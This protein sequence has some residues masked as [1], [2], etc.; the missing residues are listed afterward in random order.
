VAGGLIGS[1]L[2]SRRLPSPALRGV[3]AVVLIAAGIKLIAS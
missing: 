2:G 3:L 1:Y